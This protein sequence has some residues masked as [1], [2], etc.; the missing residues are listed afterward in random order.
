M[1]NKTRTEYSALNILT[2]LGGY[3]LNTVLGFVCRMVFVRCLAADYLGVNGLFTN[4]L[5]MLSLAEL[6]I[7]SAIVYA[8]YKP[9]AEHDEN[10]V[11][12]LMQ[13][14]AKAYRTVGCAV[15]AVGL[16]LMPFLGLIIKDPPNIS[17]SIYVLYLL[18]LFNTVTTYFFSYRIS[19]LVAAQRNYIAVG[20]NYL[21]T[22]LQSV[23]QMAA[24]LIF[25][26]YMSYILIQTCGTVAYNIIVSRIA[27]KEFPYIR[28]KDAP[29]LPKQEKKK[30]FA[31]VRDLMY[32]KISGLLVNSTDNIL[33]TF[34]KGL[35]TTGIAS[36]YT[37]LVSTL[38]SLL[39][40]IFNG[41]TAS[42]GNHNATEPDDKKLQ[43]F[44]FL[45]LMNFWIFGWAALGILF[46]ST[47]I[48]RLCFGGD[49]VLSPEIPA[50]L[51]LNFFTVGMM[52]AVWTYKHSLGLF[53][54]GRF[55]QLLTGAL[56]IGFSILLGMKWGLFGILFAT[57][58][59]RLATNLWYDPYAVFKH[60]FKRSPAPYFKKYLIYI[61]VL[62][63]AAA[64]CYFA[65]ML[66]AGPLIVRVLLEILICSVVTNA[67]FL[68]AFSR[69]PEFAKLKEIIS[70]VLGSVKKKLKRGK[71]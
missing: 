32:Y 4:I 15:A 27:S 45:N 2:G 29:P 43:M 52:N 46:C 30:L 13:I 42:I 17:E 68:L 25:R 70:S 7:G 53:R 62:A 49:Y 23:L 20:I 18:N 14:Y 6:G 65:F 50:V 26:D 64:G 8:L 16:A 22:M 61:L 55:L 59:S 31:N 51:A 67:V 57:F 40:Q 9:L 69:T 24:L 60:G 36:N 37:L 47:D 10:R 41:L 12:S 19:L 39:G 71:K 38:S 44:S 3:I 58:L 35:V 63:V 11:A 56:N 66:V 5:S 34:F 1:E 48:V 28:S 54:Y 21:I 33:I